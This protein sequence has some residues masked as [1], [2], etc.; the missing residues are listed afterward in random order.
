[1]TIFWPGPEVVTISD[2]QCTVIGAR[3]SHRKWRE[4]KEQLT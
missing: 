3:L 1:M 2:N 4:T